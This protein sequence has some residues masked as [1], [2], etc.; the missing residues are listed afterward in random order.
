MV[1]VPISTFESSGECL[2]F[3][4]R[5][6]GLIGLERTLHLDISSDPLILRLDF[7]SSRGSRL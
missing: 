1:L 3:I 6:S 4:P 2:G 7:T 5:V